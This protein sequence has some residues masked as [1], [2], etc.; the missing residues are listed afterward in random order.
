MK[1]FFSIF[2][3]FLFS[4]SLSSKEFESKYT[5]KTKGVKI[6]ELTWR[7][8]MTNDEYKTK[9]HLKSQGLLSGLYKFE[10]QYDSFGNIE[11]ETLIPLEYNQLWK[12]KKESRVVKIIFRAEAVKKL[13]LKP[14]ET[15]L[16]RIDYKKLKNY[17]DPITSLLNIL[18]KNS[19][20]NTI[21]G[22]R[23]YILEP[24]K[25]NG[26][27]KI[28]IKKFTNIWADHKRNDL[29]YLEV[30]ENNNDFLPKKIN[31]KFKNSIF[32]LIR[33]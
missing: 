21:D 29:E 6:G 25:K 8:K 13:I 20:F 28:V 23:I 30:F 7:L 1:L 17:Y 12:T 24:I 33:N 9:L 15:E 18:I 26:Y 11:N 2:F 32:S 19:S 3:I 14:I 10:G 5:I 22:R 31:I 4:E 27:Q 16:P